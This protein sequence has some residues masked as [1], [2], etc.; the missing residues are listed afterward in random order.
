MKGVIFTEFLELVETGF[1]MEAADRVITRGCPMHNCGFTSVGTYDY[2]DLIS[3]VGELSALTN[4]PPEVLV[5]A[6]GKHMF[7][8]F[9]QRLSRAFERSRRPSSCYWRVEEVIHVEV[10]KINPDAELPSFTFLQPIRIVSTLCTNPLAPLQTSLTVSSRQVSNTTVR[11]SRSDR[12]DLEGAPGTRAR[13]SI[14]PRLI[15]RPVAE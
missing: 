13:F 7:A 11:R 1:G 10:K 8:R 4:Q 15:E 14:R 2:R 3:M 9:S 5:H 12:H 6:F